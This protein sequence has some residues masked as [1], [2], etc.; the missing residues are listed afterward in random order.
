M[1]FR[2][3]PEDLIRR[4][5]FSSRV[6]SVAT[7]YL[8]DAQGALRPVKRPVSMRSALS[9]RRLLSELF[10]YAGDGASELRFPIPEN[11]YPEDVLGTQVS[12]KIARVNLSAN[13]YRYCQAL[14][15][16]TERAL[17][18]AMVNTLCAL[19]TVSA[20]RFYVEGAAAETLAGNIYLKRPLMANPGIVVEPEVT[21][22]P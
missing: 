20:V 14:D 10:Y 13:F 8:A 9:P 5:D 7:L 22:E 2:Y 16:A 1:G 21:G 6:G 19:E 17:V 18:Y 15:P 4:S 3:T 12:G 11:I